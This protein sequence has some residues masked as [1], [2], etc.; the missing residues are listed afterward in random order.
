MAY[1]KQ[2]YP[3][4]L[5][6]KVGHVKLIEDTLIQ[7][8]ISAFEDISPIA[9]EELPKISG[10][11]DLSRPCSI[12]QV[13]TVDGSHQPVPNIVRPE[14]QIGFIQVVAQ[15]LKTDILEYLKLKPMEDP[16]KVRKLLTKNTYHA[17]AALPLAGVQLKEYTVK[18]SIRSL[19]NKFLKRY[20]LYD[21]LSYLVYRKWRKNLTEKETP[22]MEC[23][24]CRMMFDLP[25]NELE[26]KCPVC[27]EKHY[28]SDY[29]GLCD[30]ESEN[31][32]RIETISSFR[33]IMELLILFSFIIKYRFNESIMSNTLFLLDGPLI[34]RAQ[35]SRLVE[36]IRALIYN[37]KKQ[38]I[39]LYLA[40]IEKSGSLRDF[41]DYYTPRLKDIGDFFI[42]TIKYIIEEIHGKSFD[43]KTYRN[44]VNYGAKIFFRAGPDHVLVLNIPT[45]MLTL[46]PKTEDLIG[47]EEIGKC[48]SNLLSYSHENALIPI[49]LANT[50]ASI[51]NQPSGGI[52]AQFVDRVLQGDL[53]E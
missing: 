25:R 24:N 44:R 1:A 11:F 19:V 32:P 53:V 17:L 5:A 27:N 10:S 50:D 15:L 47:F 33:S 14:R 43:I 49:I 20:Q 2:G 48:I 30:Y 13:I 36:P 8:T 26:F 16:R 38:N 39:P 4:E 28:L 41:A 37:Q 21:A 34:L 6:N 45:G 29:L 40:G 23:L 42:P 31:R 35:L 22:S 52:L 51:S 3:T 18:Q 12:K 46:E 9:E 7:E